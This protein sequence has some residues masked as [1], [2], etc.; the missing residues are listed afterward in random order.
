MAA[1]KRI[2][3]RR[4]AGWKMPE[5][6]IY[7]GR[8]SR[9]GNPFRVDDYPTQS[10]SI[11]GEAGDEPTPITEATRRRWAAVDFEAAITYGSGI[12]GYPSR[13]E[14][15]SELA[16]RDLACWCPEGDPCHGDVL[17]AIANQEAPDA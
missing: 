11:A 5:G 12:R 15:R 10:R 16:G 14:I 9:W 1:P 2:Q 13:D 3:R 7:V 6:A 4:T 17:L 8:P